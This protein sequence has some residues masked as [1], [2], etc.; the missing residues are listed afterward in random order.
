MARNTVKPGK[1]EGKVSTDGSDE[2][3]TLSGPTLSFRIRLFD[4]FWPDIA[5]LAMNIGLIG[6][7]LALSLTAGLRVVA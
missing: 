5:K 1:T 7:I 3:Y 4:P 2:E 6:L